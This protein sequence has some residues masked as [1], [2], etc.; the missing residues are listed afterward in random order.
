M[1]FTKRTVY[2]GYSKDT[3]DK[4]RKAFDENDLH[5]DYNIDSASFETAGRGLMTGKESIGSENPEFDNRYEIFVRKVDIDKANYYIH[6]AL[7]QN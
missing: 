6:I 5:Y 3:F 1:I 2:L 7:K 4:I